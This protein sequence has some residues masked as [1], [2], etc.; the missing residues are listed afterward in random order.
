MRLICLLLL[1]LFAAHASGD[2]Y[3]VGTAIGN[4]TPNK[5]ELESQNV[6]MGGYGL[7]KSRGPATT[8]HDPLSVR[9]ICIERDAGSFCLVVADS[10]GI[11][12][13]ISKQINKLARLNGLPGK[14]AILVSATHTHAAPDL[15]GLWG[16]APVEYE[17]RLI[18]ETVATIAAAYRAMVPS[19]LYMATT[20]A[21]AYNRRGWGFTDDAM[22]LL[23][24][25]DLENAVNLGTLINFASHPVSSPAAN[26]AVS[27]D[28]VHFLRKMMAD[29][30]HAPAIFVNGALGDVTP[31]QRAPDY[32]QSAQN[33]GGALASAAISKMPEAQ[34]IRGEISVEQRTLKLPVNNWTLNIAQ[35]LGLLSAEISGPFWNRAVET[36]V[37]YIRIGDDVEIVTLPGEPLTRLGLAVKTSMRAPLSMIFAQTDGSLGYFVPADEWETDRNDNYE[38]SVSPGRETASIFQQAILEMLR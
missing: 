12:G 25:R 10:L 28:Y 24:I 14:T 11:P 21:P 33:Y 7:W 23:I 22:S 29:Q 2:E 3:L 4:V 27:S 17:E 34:E 13:P 19:R 8:I 35:L 30:T 15:L 37:S 6:Y 16:G 9:A 18:T 38:E 20:R 32:W 36:S 5:Q 26:P 31:G 1:T